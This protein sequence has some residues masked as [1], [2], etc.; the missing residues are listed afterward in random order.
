VLSVTDGSAVANGAGVVRDCDGKP[1][2]ILVGTGSEVGLCVT[3][4][5]ELSKT[6][7]K[8]RV[9]S[10]PSWDR[11]E[12]LTKDQQQEIFP[13]NVPVLSVEAGVTMGWE[14]YADQT[15]GIN[16]F[17]TSAPGA[18]A[19]EKLG[20]S[21]EAVVQASNSLINDFKTQ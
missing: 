9:V 17:G 20:I 3:A 5:T 1:T 16:R 18:I 13:K 14:R 6:G 21:L 12:R 7:E 19:L 10:M 11:F 15:V 2:I 4:A 8:C